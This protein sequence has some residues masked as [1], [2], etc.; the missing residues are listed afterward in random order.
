AHHRPKTQREVIER[1][2]LG[3]ELGHSD[4][5]AQLAQRLSPKM[6]FQFHSEKARHSRRA[7]PPP[8]SAWSS[9]WRCHLESD[10][11][12]STGRSRDSGNLVRRGR[13]SSP[14]RGLRSR[15]RFTSSG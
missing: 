11:S 9:T 2:K 4:R 13:I 7:L 1:A 5:A 3:S 8:K 15:A 12:R 10:P 6:S 14:R